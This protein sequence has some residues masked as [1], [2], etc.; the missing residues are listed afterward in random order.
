MLMYFYSRNEIRI[1]GKTLSQFFIQKICVLVA[2]RSYSG[3]TAKLPAS[4]LWKKSFKF[5]NRLN[6]KINKSLELSCTLWSQIN[7]GW[8]VLWIN[9]ELKGF[10]I[11]NKQGDGVGTVLSV[12]SFLMI[13]KLSCVFIWYVCFTSLIFF[14][15]FNCNIK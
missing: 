8:R 14:C 1:M 7:R 9:E 5:K 10:W 6:E 11:S 12:L 4:Y 13:V 15:R 3:K 2:V